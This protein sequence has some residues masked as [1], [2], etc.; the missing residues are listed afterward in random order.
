MAYIVCRWIATIATFNGQKSL[1]ASKNDILNSPEHAIPI[2]CR[3]IYREMIL[4]A[5]R[6]KR[7][8][9]CQRISI[10]IDKLNAREREWCRAAEAEGERM[11]DKKHNNK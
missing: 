11:R 10:W 6:E 2:G 1:S 7:N 3:A 4:H 8:A 5:E 9:V